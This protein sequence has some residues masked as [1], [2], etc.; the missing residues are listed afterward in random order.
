MTNF[1]ISINQYQC[2][3]LLNNHISTRHVNA[4]KCDIIKDGRIWAKIKELI[5]INYEW[6]LK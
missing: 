1:D 5:S 2:L 4:I 6:R 3:I